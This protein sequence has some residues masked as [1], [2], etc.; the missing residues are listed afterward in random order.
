MKKSVLPLLIILLLV[1]AGC[2]NTKSSVGNEEGSQASKETIELLGMSSSEDDLNIVRDQL[3]KSGFKV[4]LNIQPDYGSYTAQKDAGNYDIVLSSWTTVT[5]NPDYAV[6][7]LFKT[8][9]DNSIMSDKQIDQLI[10]KAATETPVEYIQT[11]Q[12]LEKRLVFDKAYIAPLYNS[13][14]AQGVNKGVI[15]EKTVRLAKSRAVAWESIDFNDSS[16]RNKD[17]LITQQALASLTSLDPIKGNDGSIN[18]LNTN[19]YVR[20][21][22]LTDDDKVTSKGSLSWNHAAAKDKT[23]YYFL[24]RDDIRFAKVENKKAMDSGERVGADDVVFSLNRAKDKNAVPDHRTYSLHEHIQSA[25]VVT[26]LSELKATSGNGGTIKEEL[27]KD[28]Q[29]K[30]QKLVK[31]KEDADNQAGA[32]QVVKITTTEPFPQVLNYLAHQSA[33]IVSKK[34]IERVNTYDMDAFDPAKDIP[35]GD[36]RTITEGKMYN[37]QLFASG[38]YILSYKNDYEAVFYKNPAYMKGTENEPNISQVTVRFIENPDSALSALR[39]GEIHIFNGIP[40]TK[41]DVVEKDSKLAL[42]K[43]Q[44]NAVAYLLFN[45]S[46]REVAKS[47]ELRKAILYSINQE[48]FV[49]FYQGHKNKAS[50]TVSPLVETKN[51]LKPDAEKVKGYLTTYQKS[52]K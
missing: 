28:V 33:G 17:P 8:G 21:V 36:Q 10:D 46:K 45:T 32:Y 50:S 26:D 42:Q 43:N 25:E 34:Q 30:V 11:Y 2:V 20:L 14:K 35:Y 47:E 6:R 18:T 22:N 3:V 5:G 31:D 38:P 16:K 12:E 9:A 15:N 1:L 41:Y 7:G 49:N 39:N 52:K 23:H 29:Q 44:S 37:N 24:L 48:E 27:E 51:E 13:L 40:E 19:M 4:K